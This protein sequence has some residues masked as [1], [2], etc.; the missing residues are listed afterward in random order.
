VQ[1]LQFAL[2]GTLIFRKGR[3]SVMLTRLWADEQGAILSAELILLLSI[4]T[5]GL[6]AG[7]KALQTAVVAEFADV[8]NA[9]NSMNQSFS[10]A[11]FSAATNPSGGT[12]IVLATTA[13]SSF[14]NNV[15]ATATAANTALGSGITVIPT[16]P[17]NEGVF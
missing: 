6:I 4:M 8:A 10:F 12:Q 11:G 13:G 15:P 14:V 2:P 9:I 5:I 3:S 16:P 17:A 7:L 1:A